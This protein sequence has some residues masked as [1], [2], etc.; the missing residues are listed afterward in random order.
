MQQAGQKRFFDT[1]FFSLAELHQDLVESPQ[2]EGTESAP[3]RVLQEFPQKVWDKANAS[4]GCGLL[5]YRIL[6][7]AGKVD[8]DEVPDVVLAGGIEDDRLRV[9]ADRLASLQGVVP[10]RP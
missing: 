10:H 7:D 6:T 9:T 8:L 3:G 4:L 1:A 5:G 2:G